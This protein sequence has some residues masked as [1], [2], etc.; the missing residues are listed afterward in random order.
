MGVLQKTFSGKE[1]LKMYS[2]TFQTSKM[3]RLMNY[4]TAFSLELFSQ[5]TPS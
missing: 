3:E 2:E 1:R 4:L 5:N